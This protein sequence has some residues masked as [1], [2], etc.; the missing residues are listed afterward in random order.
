MKIGFVNT[1]H[2]DYQFPSTLA[3][4]ESAVD[5][6]KA[7]G[8]DIRLVYP[9]S[10]VTTQEQ[11]L[12]ASLLFKQNDVNSII[13]FMG[14][15]IMPS[16]ILSLIKEC[17]TI[18]VC[19]WCMPMEKRE[20]GLFTTGSYVGYA[21]FKG[22]L[23]RIGFPYTT[24]CGFAYEDA[25][26]KQLKDFILAA[27]AAQ[28]LR[29]SR[30]GLVG[31]TAMSIYPGSFDHVLLSWMVGPEVEHFDSYQIISEM[32]KITDE[33]CSDAIKLYK[34]A[35]VSD[36]PD[37]VLMRS[38]KMYVAIDRL[39]KEN[40]LTGI[41]IKCQ[42]EFSK[43]FGMT[44]CVALSVLADHGIVTSCEGDMLC[45]VSTLILHSLS[46]ETA[47]YG[48]IMHHDVE[49]NTIKVSPCGFLPFALGSEGACRIVQSQDKKFA[50]IKCSFVMHPGKV[51]I[52]RVVEDIGKYH[53]VYSV[54]EGLETE[55]RGGSM[56]ALDIKLNGKVT[57]LF[58]KLAGQHFAICYGDYSDALRNLGTILNMEVVEV[59]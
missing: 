45:L 12:D 16:A 47:T 34:E 44:P 46:G 13:I 2:P 23:D 27:E 50:G 17:R 31:Y 49:K 7:L 39:C 35:D 3:Y 40:K 19:I 6:L 53:L 38:C 43:M 51:T 52:L 10:P 55:L 14:A 18:P 37:P 8:S 26:K 59:K 54:G 4:G 25:A 21:L 9:D 36:V 56:P 11:A 58:A 48:D 1:C 42:Y 20:K 15:Y 5:A 24:V 57:D 41:T 32:E 33:E 22:T 30:L 29:R 28:Y